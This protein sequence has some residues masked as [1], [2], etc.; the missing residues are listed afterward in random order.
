MSNMYNDNKECYINFLD[1]IRKQ[2]TRRKNKFENPACTDY[3]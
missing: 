2:I 3:S 1:N